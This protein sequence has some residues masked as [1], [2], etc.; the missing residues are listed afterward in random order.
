MNL[1]TL[2]M[3]P[4]ALSI[5]GCAIAEACG[6][7]QTGF[8]E[9]LKAG[10]FD[11]AETVLAQ[12]GTSCPAKVYDNTQRQFTESIAI[13]AS[14]WLAE[15][16]TAEAATLI[17]RAKTISW[18]VYSV[19]GDLAAKQQDWRTATEEYLLAYEELSSN[20][21]AAQSIPDF[22]QRKERIRRL[23]EEAQ[24]VHGEIVAVV[25]RDG[26]TQIVPG[27]ARGPEV[28]QDI[29]VQFDTDSAALNPAGITSAKLI[30]DDLKRRDG[31]ARILVVGHTDERGTDEHNR[32]LSERRAQAVAQYLKSHGISAPITHEGRG[33]SEPKEISSEAR[34]TQEE[35]W[36][37]QRR[38][39]VITE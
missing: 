38:V 17:K 36:A 24:L 14:R 32:K 34:Y 10:N 20:P 12:I 25:T 37:I 35:K 29:P 3:I 27:E 13:T 5:S 23:A 22:A 4:L 16:K 19:R 18:T 7:L 28:E 39:Q 33:E 8:L 21:K 9:Q 2:F 1:A 30:L 15:N 11:A 6:P 31:L 26:S